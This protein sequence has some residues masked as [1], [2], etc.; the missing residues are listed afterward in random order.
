M[1]IWL[2][3]IHYYLIHCHTGFL[4]KNSHMKS[5]RYLAYPRNPQLQCCDRK[6]R[7]STE[8]FVFFEGR[9]TQISEDNIEL[10]DGGT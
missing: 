6:C 2:M 4:K 10:G 3:T 5:Q 9:Q 8:M 1:N 7:A